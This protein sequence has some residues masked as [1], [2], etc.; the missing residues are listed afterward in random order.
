M[1]IG[2]FF[3]PN[4]FASE[5]SRGTDAGFAAALDAVL[6]CGRANTAEFAVT[7]TANRKIPTRLIRS[8]FTQC[9]PSLSR[10]GYSNPISVCP[11]LIDVQCQDKVIPK[12]KQPTVPSSTCVRPRGKTGPCQRTPTEP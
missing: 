5:G 2:A 8:G 9:S 12:T 1:V 3:D 6:V 11:A 4:D 10:R 7:A